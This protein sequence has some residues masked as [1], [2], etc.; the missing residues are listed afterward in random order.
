MTTFLSLQGSMAVGKT[1]ALKYLQ[2]HNSEVMVSYEENRQIIA[3][4]QARQLDKT[5]F[6]DYIAIQRLFIENELTR[7][8][9]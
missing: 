7:Y 3:E 1:T 6:E 4:I 5:K 2:Q 8:A 9:K